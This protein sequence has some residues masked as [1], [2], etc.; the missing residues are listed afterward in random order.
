MF[1]LQTFKLTYMVKSVLLD[2]HHP[3]MEVPHLVR[4]CAPIY[5]KLDGILELISYFS[6]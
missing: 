5:L 4:V 6:L 2:C 3:L 1:K